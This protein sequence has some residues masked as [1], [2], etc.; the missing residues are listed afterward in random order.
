M[1]STKTNDRTNI[2]EGMTF[3]VMHLTAFGLKHIKEI[4]V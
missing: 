4:N 2:E 3:N 1:N